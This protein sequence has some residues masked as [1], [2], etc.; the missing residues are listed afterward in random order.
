MVAVKGGIFLIQ[1]DGSLTEMNPVEYENEDQL[2]DLLARY[3]G[4]I[5]GD[6]VDHA[7][8]RRWLM[9]TRELG[10]A[11]EEGGNDR[12]SADHLFLDQDAIPTIIEV[13]RAEDIRIRREVVSQMLDYA[14]NAV[15]AIPMERIRALYEESLHSK[16]LDPQLTFQKTLDI[17]ISYEDYWVKVKNNLQAGK[18]RLLF[19]ADEIPAELRRVVEFLNEQMDPAEVLAVEIRKFSGDNSVQALVPMV[20]GQ[21]VEAQ[22]KKKGSG[23]IGKQ[24]DWESFAER[25]AG[26]GQNEVTAARSILDW[27]DQNNIEVNWPANQQGSFILGF[28]SGNRVFYPLRVVGDGTIGWNVPHQGDKS[29]PPFDR[30]EKRR[31]LLEHMKSIKGVNV[32]INNIDGYKA[33]NFPL[34]IIIDND[35]RHDFYEVLLWIKKEMETYDGS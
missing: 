16:G 34:Q 25:L 23:T 22:I 8:P 21:T 19:V 5:A 3:P 14:A 9:V 7:Q 6:Q 15:V 29:P 35:A 2:Q 17:T 12:W 18:I 1:K 4:L 10:I 33:L 20:M 24:W 32:D 30:R 31:E 26:S 27:A 28:N 13:K 11:S